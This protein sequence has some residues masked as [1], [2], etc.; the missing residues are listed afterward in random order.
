MLLIFV[1]KLALWRKKIK[2]MITV[3][4]NRA[5]TTIIAT[6]AARFNK[7]GILNVIIQRINIMN[8]YRTKSCAK[9]EWR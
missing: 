3:T 2:K 8:L 9:S 7:V 1:L 5:T 4:N 6:L